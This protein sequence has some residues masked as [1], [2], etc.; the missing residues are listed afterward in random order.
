MR[1]YTRLI[2]HTADIVLAIHADTLDDLFAAAARF[3][4]CHTG[5]R[6]GEPDYTLDVTLEARDTATL[7]ADWIN[8]VLARSE[9]ACAALMPEAISVGHGA[10]TARLRAEP[11]V[12]W[13]CFLKAATYHDLSLQRRRGRWRARVLCDV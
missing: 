4:A 12:E 5:P 13:R 7:L 8:E 9:I 10:L 1:P 3:V 2:P 6:S 11:L